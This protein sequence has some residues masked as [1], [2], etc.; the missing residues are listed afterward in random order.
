[1]VPDSTIV[2]VL[3]S[4]ENSFLPVCSHPGTRPHLLHTLCLLI[5][6]KRVEACGV[7]ERAP[8]PDNPPLMVI[9]CEN[10]SVVCNLPTPQFPHL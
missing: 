6:K 4:E 5:V 2:G 1:M 3:L 9:T 8:E 7:L 10:L